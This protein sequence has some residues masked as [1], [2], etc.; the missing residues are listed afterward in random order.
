MKTAFATLGLALLVFAGC[1]GQKKTEIDF[2]Q[3]NID[4][5]VAQHTLHTDI[6]EKSGTVMNPSPIHKD[7][8]IH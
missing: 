4:N 6:I 5:A 7:G 3:D 2:I 8:R 1:A